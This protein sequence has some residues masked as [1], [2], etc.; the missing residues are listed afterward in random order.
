MSTSASKSKPMSGVGSSRV[1]FDRFDLDL[2]S[3]ELRKD[4]RR[5]RL[6]E[7]PFQLLALLIDH[8]GEVVTRDEVCRTLWKTDTF[9]DFDHSVAAAIN[10]I[11]DALDDSAENPRFVETLP[12]RGY[13]FIAQIR[14]DMPA[15]AALPRSQ[16]V[17]WLST[18][19]ARRPRIVGGI[20]IT[21]V[22]LLVT[23]GWKMMRDGG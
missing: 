16:G 17:P 3:G 10:K 11:R 9:L 19:L 1:V 22:A 15:A 5:I 7:Q 13:R 20:S 12:R 18:W 23:L 8:A 6:Q 14:R 4:T 21:V 2:R